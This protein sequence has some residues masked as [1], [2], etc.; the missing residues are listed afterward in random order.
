MPTDTFAPVNLADLT[1]DEAVVIEQVAGVSPDEMLASFSSGR[2]RSSEV[3]AFLLVAAR[4]VD[5]DVELADL[6]R[7]TYAEAFTAAADV[8]VAGRRD[9]DGPDGPAASSAPDGPGPRPSGTP[10][11]RISAL[12]DE[13]PDLAEHLERLAASSTPS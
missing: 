8:L 10:Q 6:G 13:R 7:M 2:P 11:E 1:L 3:A 4:R 9:D 5:P 12:L